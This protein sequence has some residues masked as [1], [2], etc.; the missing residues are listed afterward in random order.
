MYI[1][2]L[3]FTNEPVQANNKTTHWDT[4]C[5]R[6]RKRRYVR[7]RN[8]GNNQTPALFNT[9]HTTSDITP[10]VCGTIHISNT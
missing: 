5:V 3:L 1:Y 6:K 7:T 4:T 2:T 8:N 10:T 9:H